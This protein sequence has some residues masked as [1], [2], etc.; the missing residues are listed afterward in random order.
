MRKVYATF[1]L[2]FVLVSLVACRE[3]NA[4]DVA[5][6]VLTNID[7]YPPKDE[8][9][10]AE[11]AAPFFAQLE[12]IWDEDN[13]QMWGV[14]LHS[15]VIIFC[16]D[17]GRV[18]ANRPDA[19]G[20]LE[21]ANI[22]GVAIYIGELERRIFRTELSHGFWNNERAIF[23]RLDYMLE[24]AVHGETHFIYTH[25][26]IIGDINHYIVHWMQTNGMLPAG[27]GQ[28]PGGS[29][30][31]ENDISYMM[32]INAL[33]EAILAQDEQQRISHTYNALSIR[34]SR[35]TV[36]RIADLGWRENRQ[37]V[38]EGLPMFTEM[39]LPLSHSEL[40]YSI[41]M[42]SERILLWDW[43]ISL[44]YAYLG[45]ALYGILLDANEIIWRPYVVVDIDLGDLLIAHL[46]IGEFIPLYD[47]DLE[48]YGYSE[49]SRRLIELG[50]R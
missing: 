10:L 43:D 16:F 26:V 3:D 37:I 14:P 34:H 5:T 48:R 35:R 31:K 38:H 19:G 7:E 30:S 40:M 18:V 36:S 22:D 20:E 4:V 42:W 12:S 15:A 6:E 32:E 41:K 47:I 39:T 50:Y 23:Y 25:N 8:F 33:I 27:L 49:V 46:G 44:S 17:T 45:G 28:T 11:F 1:L 9:P 13:G 2:L 24:R 21:Y 29:Y